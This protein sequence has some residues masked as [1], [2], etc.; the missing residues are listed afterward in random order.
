MRF[1]LKGRSLKHLDGPAP[2]LHYPLLA[3]RRMLER[4]LSPY[5]SPTPPA[6]V[7]EVRRFL[8]ACGYAR[9]RDLYGKADHWAKPADYERNR[10][11][12][13]EDAALW[14][15]HWLLHLGKKARFAWR[16]GHAFVI[17][18]GAKGVFFLDRLRIFFPPEQ[19]PWDHSAVAAPAVRDVERA[20]DDN[21]FGLVAVQAETLREPLRPIMSV[22]GRLRFY[23]HGD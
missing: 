21:E 16:S 12:D 4:A 9:D 14:A 3:V 20:L 19:G 18:Y 2:S 22:D 8:S 23:Q 5:E 10:K 1:S 7:E 13:C 17:L 15:W 11:G 6:N